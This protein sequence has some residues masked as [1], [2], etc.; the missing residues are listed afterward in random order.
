MKS[1]RRIHRPDHDEI[2]CGAG[3]MHVPR[4]L[5]AVDGLLLD[6]LGSA[7]CLR[8]NPF[9]EIEL[10]LP[11][12]EILAEETSARAS[13]VR[14]ARSPLAAVSSVRGAVHPS[15]RV[16]REWRLFA[17]TGGIVATANRR[18]GGRCDA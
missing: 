5:A 3:A 8:K 11:L 16:G 17:A 6:V 12:L 4:V 9:G 13:V 15:R 7:S 2:H 14:Q 18:V 10:T 1:L